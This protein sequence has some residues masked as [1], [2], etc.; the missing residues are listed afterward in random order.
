MGPLQSTRPTSTRIV[1]ARL[2][3]QVVAA[4]PGVSAT[5]E[6]GRWLT[7]DGDRVIPGVVAAASG[8]GR[9]DVDLH[10]LAF[11]PPRPLEHQA[12]SIRAALLEAAQRTG[13][14]ASLGEIDVTIH[15]LVAPDELP[16][17]GEP[18][19]GVGT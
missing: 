1:I 6:G 8:G 14:A 2:A 12:A 17:L 4:D 5:R 11:M 13:V 10:L 7:R 19:A 18:G 16:G 3:E 9:V 15:D